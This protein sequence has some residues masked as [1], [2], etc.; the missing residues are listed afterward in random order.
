MVSHGALTAVDDRLGSGRPAPVPQFLSD[1]GGL[2]T[3][4]TTAALCAAGGR[5]GGRAPTWRAPAGGGAA[6]AAGG[7]G[8]GPR[9]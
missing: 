9:P 5:G 7:A 6:H 1:L 3:A 8:G 4:G 2:P